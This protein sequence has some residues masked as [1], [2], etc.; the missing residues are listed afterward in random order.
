MKKIIIYFPAGHPAV[1]HIVEQSK[2]FGFK[3]DVNNIDYWRGES[4]PCDYVIVSG[5]RATARKIIQAYGEDKCMVMDWGYI[6]RVNDPKERS[7]NYW[8]LSP[9]KLNNPPSYECDNKRFNKLGLKVKPPTNKKTGYTLVCGQ[10]PQ[11]GAVYKHNHAQWIKEQLSKYDDSV[12]REHPRG[13]VKIKHELNTGSLEDAF[14]GSK[15]V[16]CYNSNVGHDAMLEGVSVISDV[17]A[18]FYGVGKS[19][20]ERQAYF[21]RAAYGQWCFSEIGEGIKYTIDNMHRWN[22][23]A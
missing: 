20:K 2:Q 3:I 8:Q 12:Y 23:T 7:T 16:V 4:L 10:M 17:E 6:K 21:N 9:N 1:N 11:D 18:P 13:G 15:Q 19:T 22:T 14:K 5:H